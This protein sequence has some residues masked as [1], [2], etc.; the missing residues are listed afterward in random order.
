MTWKQ[1]KVGCAYFQPPTRTL[2]IMSDGQDV[3]HLDFV[4]TGAVHAP[5]LLSGSTL[6]SRRG[7]RGPVKLQ[8]QPALILTSAG[9]DEAFLAALRGD[10]PEGGGTSAHRLVHTGS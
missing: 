10:G 1:Y 5:C 3:R 2:Y 7:G 6:R 8:A 4:E 9:H